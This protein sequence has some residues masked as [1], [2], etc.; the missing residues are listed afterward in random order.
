[1]K[2]K[3]LPENLGFCNGPFTVHT[4]RTMM[5][6]ELEELLDN[7][8]LGTTRDD[9]LKSI[10]ES[11]ILAKPTISSRNKTAKY[12]SGLYSLSTNVLV[13]RILRYFWQSEKDGHALLAFLCAYARDS[14]LR[15]VADVILSISVGSE[16]SLDYIKDELQDKHPGRFSP[17][18]LH[19]TAQ[20]I[21][22][23]FQQSGLLSG[24]RIKIRTNPSVTPA[25]VAY[26]LLL[27]Y[28]SGVRGQSLFKT[29]W[30]KLLDISQDRIANFASQAHRLGWMEFRNFGNVVDISF[31][32]LLTKE[33]KE[34]IDGT[35]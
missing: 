30:A 4:S 25:N 32:N 6:K 24:R 13:F 16:L 20:N 10:I 12:I 35:N 23:S 34:A 8:Q 21:A 15:D 3:L 28:L 26:A 2:S 17:R 1:M 22:S 14:L 19:S 11:N 7:T 18:T 5:F 27:G 9:Y 29:E 33:E 31:N